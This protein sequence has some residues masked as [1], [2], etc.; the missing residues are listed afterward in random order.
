CVNQVDGLP[1]VAKQTVRVGQASRPRRARLEGSVIVCVCQ[2]RPPFV[3][4]RT[5]SLGAIMEQTPDTGHRTETNGVD[6]GRDPY[7][8]CSRVQVLPAFTVR[9]TVA[10]VPTAT[11]SEIDEQEM[12]S[13]LAVVGLV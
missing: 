8:P 7:E 2:V 9:I 6:G 5:T 11:H 12:S 3:V 13:R 10:F 1:L 4:R